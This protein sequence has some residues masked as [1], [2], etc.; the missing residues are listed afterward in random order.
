MKKILTVVDDLAEDLELLYPY[1]R[2][3]EEGYQVDMAAPKKGR[4]FQR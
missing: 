4:Q 2:M 1:Y 3:M